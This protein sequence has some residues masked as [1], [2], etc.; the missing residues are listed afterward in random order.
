MNYEKQ[1]M[2]FFPKQEQL[3]SQFNSKKKPRN[4]SALPKQNMS[5]SQNKQQ[6]T[7]VQTTKVPGTQK[8][9]RKE[10]DQPRQCSTCWT[11]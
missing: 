4:H 11:E 9:Q 2:Q 8:S 7:L 10:D 3:L 6:K 1:F 5:L